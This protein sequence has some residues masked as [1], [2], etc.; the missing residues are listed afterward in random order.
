MRAAHRRKDQ[1]SMADS[2]FAVPAGHGR[3]HSTA[4][5]NK[6][7]IRIGVDLGGTK[8][9]LVALDRNGREIFRRRVPAPRG[10]Y[11]ATLDA[12][13]ALVQEVETALGSAPGAASVGIGTPG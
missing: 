11:H 6:D 2:R 7:R 10:D 9:E 4:A 13:V 8:I 12:I 3:A 5:M 1:A